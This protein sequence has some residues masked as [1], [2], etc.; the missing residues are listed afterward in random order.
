MNAHTKFCQVARDPLRDQK[1]R[2][3]LITFMQIPIIQLK[4][5]WKS[6]Q[7]FWDNLAP[8]KKRNDIGL[9]V[10]CDTCLSLSPNKLTIHECRR[11]VQKF[12]LVTGCAF[13]SRYNLHKYKYSIGISAFSLLATC[14]CFI[15]ANYLSILWTMVYCCRSSI[16]CI[17]SKL[18]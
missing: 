12:L 16:C 3:G 11:H 8:V 10:T 6:V 9:A 5:W 2:S 14:E 15:I 1:K 4:K 7:Y 18:W 13:Y 17:H